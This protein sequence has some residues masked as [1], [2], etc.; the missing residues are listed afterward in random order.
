MLISKL[1]ATGLLLVEVHIAAMQLRVFIYLVH[2][3]QKQPVLVKVVVHDVLA[4]IDEKL[5]VDQKL[6]STWFKSFF[7][8]REEQGKI[9]PNTPIEIVTLT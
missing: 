4:E 6:Q 7:T 9:V 1:I 8:E 5:V 2:Q 3:A